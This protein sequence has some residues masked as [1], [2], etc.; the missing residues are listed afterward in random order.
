MDILYNNTRTKINL[1]FVI[2]SFKFFHSQLQPQSLILI[3]D[4]NLLLAETDFLQTTFKVSADYKKGKLVVSPYYLN[5]VAHVLR[6]D[7]LTEVCD[8][9][10][11]ESVFLDF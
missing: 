7:C 6:V 1:T 4:G 8:I 9:F 3:V 11:M 2:T 5:R 10:N